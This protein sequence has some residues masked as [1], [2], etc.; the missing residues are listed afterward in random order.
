MITIK[1]KEEIEIMRGGGEILAKIMKELGKKV[2]PGIT[3]KKLDR[4]A[5]SLILKSGGK[6]SFKGYE[7]YPFCLCT[8][9]NKEIVHALPSDK[10]LKEGEI[11]SLDLGIL[12]NGFHTD[13]AV[14]FPVGKVDPE[15]QRLIRVTKK[16]L[17]RGIKK[18]HPGNTFG[19]IGN[20]IQRYVEG[21]GF[22]VVRDLCG[23]GIGREIHEEPQILNYGKRHTGPEIKEGMTFCIEPMVTAGNWRIKKTK[24]GFGYQTEDG[25]LSAHFEHTMA[26]TK[27][28]CQVLTNLK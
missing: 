22:N 6:C 23:H 8:S 14:T 27:D 28:G 3:T 21:Q 25:S 10:A 20:T 9:I 4:L 7:G 2:Q 1:S 12:Y 15:T 26:V 16:S 19:D 11:I 5:E 24:D 13:M 18:V 17:K